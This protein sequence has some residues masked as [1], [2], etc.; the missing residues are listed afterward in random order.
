MT[1][2]DTLVEP[3]GKLVI[4]SVLFKILFLEFKT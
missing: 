1:K 2:F 3:F 4:E